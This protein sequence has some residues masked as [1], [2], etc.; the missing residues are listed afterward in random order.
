MF[1]GMN[2]DPL[3]VA[4]RALFFRLIA[5]TFFFSRAAVFEWVACLFR[6]AFPFIII[7]FVPLLLLL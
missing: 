5:A 2:R 3:D 7:F 1:A 4:A 6:K